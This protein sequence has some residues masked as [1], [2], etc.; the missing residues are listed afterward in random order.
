MLLLSGAT[1]LLAGTLG[2]A[3]LFIV[4]AI[5]GT[6][7]APLI[8]AVFFYGVG[9]PFIFCICVLLVGFVLL[10]KGLQEHFKH[11]L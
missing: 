7:P 1:L 8:E 5:L 2:T 10:G 11:K 6:G 4:V 3:L 9:L